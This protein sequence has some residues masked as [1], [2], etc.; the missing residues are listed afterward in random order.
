MAQNYLPLKG[1]D[2]KLS[3]AFSSEDDSL[4]PNDFYRHFHVCSKIRGHRLSIYM[5]PILIQNILCIDPRYR[6]IDLK[7]RYEESEKKREVQN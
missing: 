5:H 2:S 4:K 7:R 6:I 3:W 1:K